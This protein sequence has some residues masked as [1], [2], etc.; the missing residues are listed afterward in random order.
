MSG[1]TKRVKG[2]AKQAAGVIIGDEEL[3]REGRMDERAG[4]LEEKI[5]DVADA[6]KDKVDKASRKK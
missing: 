1:N 2:R 6:V 5:D 4:D 3:Q